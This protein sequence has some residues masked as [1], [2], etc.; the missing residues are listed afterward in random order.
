MGFN[1]L[2]ISR[3]LSKLE[4]IEKEIHKSAK[5]KGLSEVE[6]KVI[7]ADFCGKSNLEFYQGLSDK[8]LALKD[9]EGGPI[10]IGLYILNAGLNNV[11]VFDEL[12]IS[13][14]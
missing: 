3:T 12:D 13:S 1:I 9:K 5:E 8:I 2:L 7:Q 10:D 14:I 11:G 4:R 6:T